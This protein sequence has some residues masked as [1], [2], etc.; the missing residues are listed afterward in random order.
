MKEIKSGSLIMPQDLVGYSF[1]GRIGETLF[2]EGT[3]STIRAINKG[4]VYI[5]VLSVTGGC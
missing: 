3:N 5:K 4:N 1:T 2:Y